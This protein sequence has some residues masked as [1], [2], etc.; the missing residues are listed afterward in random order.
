MVIEALCQRKSCILED[1]AEISSLL[2]IGRG[3]AASLAEKEVLYRKVM[4]RFGQLSTLMRGL[5]LLQNALSDA[6]SDQ[7]SLKAVGNTLISRA[8]QLYDQLS[9]LESCFSELSEDTKLLHT[10]THQSS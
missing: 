9:T 5:E 2:E 7:I 3:V 4:S 6:D 10:S 1:W 8:T